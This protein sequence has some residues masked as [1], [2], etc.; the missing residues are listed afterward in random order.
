MAQMETVK[1]MVDDDM[2][3]MKES[4]KRKEKAE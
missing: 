2:E 3:Q 4:K 1:E